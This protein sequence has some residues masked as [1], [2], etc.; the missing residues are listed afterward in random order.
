MRAMSNERAVIDW[1]A[2]ER[3]YRAGILSLREIGLLHGCSHVAIKKRADKEHWSRDLTAK[4]RAK[5]EELVNAQSVIPTAQERAEAKAVERQIVETNALRVAEVRMAH[6]RD[7]SRMRALVVQLLAECEALAGNPDALRD[8]AKHVNAGDAAKAL[9]SLE[10]V[11]S[12]SARIKSVKELAEA[13]KTLVALEREAYGINLLP[14]A[15][16]E[17][18]SAA[19]LSLNDGAKR[20]A[21]MLAAAARTQGAS[22]VH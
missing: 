5:A 4:I 10:R 21:F 9:E 7:I 14:E 2:I 16:V 18:N 8:L 12:L 11:T 20:I 17:E 19:P 6:R 15:P 13:M 22:S 1:E 3:D